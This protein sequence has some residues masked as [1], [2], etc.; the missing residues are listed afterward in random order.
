[1]CIVPYRLAVACTDNPNACQ[2]GSC[3]DDGVCA[4]D[5]P[6]ILE[7][8]A[9]DVPDDRCRYGTYG[10]D[11]EGDRTGACTLNPTLG[12]SCDGSSL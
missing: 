3:V 5:V 11:P 2:A 10:H 8:G 4:F 1:M 9:R 7:G 12:E 6:P